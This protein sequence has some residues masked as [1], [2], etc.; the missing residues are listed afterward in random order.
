M[1]RLPDLPGVL[2]PAQVDAT[3]DA[4][5]QLQRR[6]GMIPWFAGGHADPWNHTEAAMALVAAGRRAEADR[7]FDWLAA[8]QHDDGSWCS[9]YLDDGIEDPRRDANI[10]TYAAVGVW[11]HWLVTGDGAALAARF[12]MVERALDFALGLQQPGGEVLWSYEPDDGRPG[13]FAL[14]TGSSSVLL[15]LRCGVAAARGGGTGPARVGVSR[16]AS[17]RGHRRARV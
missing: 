2:S 7:A 3:A 15:A 6:N 12:G 1:A 4:I 8:T 17:G 9:Y 10:S 13:E 16:A 14:L 11:H 5:A